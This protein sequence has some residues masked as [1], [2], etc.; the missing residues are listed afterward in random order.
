MKK[1]IKR[2]RRNNL[3]WFFQGVFMGCLVIIG[4]N[5]LDYV[6]LTKTYPSVLA[7]AENCML[8]PKGD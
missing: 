6:I 8:K 5:S 2:L 7:Q 3:K 1:I 4:L